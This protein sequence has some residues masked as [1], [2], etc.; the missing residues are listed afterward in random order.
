MAFF[1]AAALGLSILEAV[2][3]DQLHQ[4]HRA[5]PALAVAT[6][7]AHSIRL[8]GPCSSCRYY[9][10]SYCGACH[11]PDCSQYTPSC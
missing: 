6:V 4:L 7:C 5:R 8:S 11:N 10:C 9:E 1:I 3:Q 2:I